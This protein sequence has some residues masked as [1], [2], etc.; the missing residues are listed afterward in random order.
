MNLSDRELASVLAGLRLLQAFQNGSSA[1]RTAIWEIA[2]DG[3]DEEPMTSSE[4]DR[5]CESLN[6]NI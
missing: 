3:G 5:L 4:I 6:T 2:T 1:D